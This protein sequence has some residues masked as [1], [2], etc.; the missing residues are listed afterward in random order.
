MFILT[1]HWSPVSGIRP[2]AG[3]AVDRAG[4]LLCENLSLLGCNLIGLDH[5]VLDHTLIIRREMASKLC[6]KLR[7]LL[8]HF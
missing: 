2:L 3:T 6:I 4:L 5:N 1:E 8:L 7:L